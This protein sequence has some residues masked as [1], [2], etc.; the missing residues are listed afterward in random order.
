MIITEANFLLLISQTSQTPK[1]F[2][3]DDM[4][5]VN[6]RWDN[7]PDNNEL[8]KQT[9]DAFSVFD[10]LVLFSFSVNVKVLQR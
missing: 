10:P 8:S 6:P 3:F 4:K 5:A 9:Y 2:R 1:D 7:D